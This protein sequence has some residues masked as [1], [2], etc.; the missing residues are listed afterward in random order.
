MYWVCNVST[1]NRPRTAL[2]FCSVNG[3]DARHR[4][5]WAE[6]RQSPTPAEWTRQQRDAVT[7][8][9]RGRR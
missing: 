9:R 6:E 7:K 5:S 2:A 3:R 1:C 4:D 8:E